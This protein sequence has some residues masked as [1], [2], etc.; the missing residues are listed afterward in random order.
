M[1]SVSEMLTPSVLGN[2]A[3]GMA[4]TGTDRQAPLSATEY[5][6]L[7]LSQDYCVFYKYYFAVSC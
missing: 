1:K 6:G 7:F 5:T 4:R 3:G 2:V